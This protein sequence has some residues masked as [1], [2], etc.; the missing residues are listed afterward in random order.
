LATQL[1]VIA[2]GINFLEEPPVSLRETINKN[3]GPAAGVAGA[4]IVIGIIVIFLSGRS[5]KP[6][7]APPL[8]T[9]AYFS[10]DDGKTYFVDDIT[11]IPPFDHNG[12]KAYMAKVFATPDNQRFVGYLQGFDE[13]EKKKIQDAISRGVP[14]SQAING[15]AANVKK[16]GGTKWLKEGKASTEELGKVQRPTPP[17]GKADENVRP[18]RP[19][20]EDM[21]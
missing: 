14:P 20:A 5:S 1:T 4:V 18:V 21:K 7:V 11:N 16:P 8:P 10:D 12:K 13:P 3:P 19:T 9:K 6:G 15:F 17:G 2:T